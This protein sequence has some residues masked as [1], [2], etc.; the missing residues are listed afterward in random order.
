M[1][2]DLLTACATAGFPLMDYRPKR[3][4]A[5]MDDLKAE[6]DAGR[7][8]FVSTGGKRSRTTASEVPPTRMM[9]GQTL[10]EVR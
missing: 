2:E 1:F 10:W 8:A 9:P 4:E 5:A 6:V 7:A 3:W